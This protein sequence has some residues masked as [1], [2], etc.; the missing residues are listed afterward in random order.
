[1]KNDTLKQTIDG[2][3]EAD[4]RAG[5]GKYMTDPLFH[6]DIPAPKKRRRRKTPKKDSEAT[7]LR[8]CLIYLKKC[9]DTVFTERRNT[10]AVAF[11][12]G[13]FIRFGTPGA[14]D[15]WC[16]IQGY[17][18]DVM[19]VPILIHIEIECK[20]RDGKG[21]LNPAQRAFKQFCEKSGIPYFVVTSRENLIEQL[22]EAG[23]MP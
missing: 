12:D 19:N 21:K 3:P 22:K 1:M 23:F 20:R 16:L 17:A 4:R 6:D 7:V 8:E 11:E 9:P 14:A 10:G 5:R 15:I 18:Q 2:I 13:G